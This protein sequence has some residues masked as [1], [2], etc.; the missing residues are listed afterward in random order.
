[1]K[2]I[3]QNWKKISAFGVIYAVVFTAVLALFS[4]EPSQIFANVIVST[5]IIM[6]IINY[7]GIFK[8]S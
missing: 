1:M 3:L 8:K 5:L 7:I 6:G 4:V 2:L